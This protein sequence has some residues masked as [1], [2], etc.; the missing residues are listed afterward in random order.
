M[1]VPRCCNYEIIDFVMTQLIFIYQHFL[2]FFSGKQGPSEFNIDA[3]VFSYC[4]PVEFIRV[5]I[6][7]SGAFYI[8]QPWK[9]TSKR[10]AKM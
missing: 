6:E 1:K 7:R 9:I 4:I 8:Y 3:W 2:I 5:S 10:Q